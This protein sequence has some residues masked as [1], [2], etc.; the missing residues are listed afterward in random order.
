MHATGTPGDWNE[1]QM[2][3]PFLSEECLI[4]ARKGLF[5]HAMGTAG[6]LELTAQ[7]LGPKVESSD[8]FWIP[9]C[10]IPSADVHPS[11]LSLGHQLI[12]DKPR[13][14]STNGKPLLCGK[15]SM[16]IG[17]ISSCVLAQREFRVNGCE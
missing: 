5:G 16:G 14:I 12:L 13:N 3:S 7:L 6:G 10:G 17:G 1:L 2:T 15:L 11:F 8:T 4:S 9:G